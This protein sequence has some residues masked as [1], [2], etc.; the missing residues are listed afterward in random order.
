MG[1]FGS[2][3]QSM[4]SGDGNL[5]SI[6]CPTREQVGASRA[7]AGALPACDAR[8]ESLGERR[9]DE[10]AI[11]PRPCI[12]GESV[13]GSNRCQGVTW[14]RCNCSEYVHA[15]RWCRPCSRATAWCQWVRRRS[16]RR[17]LRRSHA[18]EHVGDAEGTRRCTLPAR[19][20]RSRCHLHQADASLGSSCVR[21][22]PRGAR[23][24]GRGRQG[25]G[26]CHRWASNQTWDGHNVL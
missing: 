7:L 21:C 26:R 8:S 20:L 23:K 2:K 18:Q 15:E 22:R 24:L 6:L 5:S 13:T 9:L 1:V 10:T 19:R 4:R 17:H 25:S 12:H 16:G 14:L 11:W 3:S